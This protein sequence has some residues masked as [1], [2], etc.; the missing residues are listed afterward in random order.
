MECGLLRDEGFPL[1]RA[2]CAA[3]PDGNV[4]CAESSGMGTSEC[5]LGIPK[6]DAG[7]E[8]R[9]DP[10]DQSTTA[11]SVRAQVSLLSGA[12]I[13]LRRT[14]VRLSRVQAAIA[15]GGL[16]PALF[17][18]AADDFLRLDFGRDTGGAHD[19]AQDC[20]RFRRTA[21]VH[22]AVDAFGD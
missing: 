13:S 1:Q 3:I 4:Q 18:G 8:L 6:P 5:R 22:S 9:A 12:G 16:K 19:L 15:E 2:A 7:G 20:C 10:F 11:D 21:E 17:H 14:S